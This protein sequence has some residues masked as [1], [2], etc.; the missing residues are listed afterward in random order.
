[1]ICFIESNG[2]IKNVRNTHMKYGYKDLEWRPDT[3]ACPFQ[4]HDD[5]G[6]R[7]SLFVMLKPKA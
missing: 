3:Q 7:K 2:A 6:R 1:M 4:D 5:H